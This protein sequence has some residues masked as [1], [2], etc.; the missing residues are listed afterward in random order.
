MNTVALTGTIATQPHH[1]WCRLGRVTEF[2]LDV[3]PLSTQ[4][5]PERF[6]VVAH[7]TLAR[8]TSRLSVGCAIAVTGV[9]RSDPVD[10]PDCSVWHRVE[11]AADTIHLVA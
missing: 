7:H 10:M 8:D 5:Q 4:R 11:I 1:T 3:A 9:L 2:D 6:H